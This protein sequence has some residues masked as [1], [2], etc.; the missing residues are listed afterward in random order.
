MSKLFWNTLGLPFVM[1]VGRKG[2][3][4]LC[5]T[6]NQDY[7]FLAK[8]ALLRKAKEL[9]Q[10]LFKIN[11]TAT[12]DAYLSLLAQCEYFQLK[13]KISDW[14]RLLLLLFPLQRPPQTHHKHSERLPIFLGGKRMISD[15]LFSCPSSS[16]PT[17]VSVLHTHCSGFKAFQTKLKPRKTDGGQKTWPEQQK[18]NDNYKY[19]DNGNEN[20]KNI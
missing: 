17:L 20:D 1:F 5:E 4:D 10:H 13:N 16:R 18:D 8:L 19:K 15:S 6:L 12:P 14:V 3:E 11:S 9:S 7:V 2:C